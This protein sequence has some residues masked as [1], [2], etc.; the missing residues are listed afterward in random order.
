MTVAMVVVGGAIGA[1]LRYVVEVFVR[2]RHHGAFPWGTFVVNVSGA[3]VL[4]V[5]AGVVDTVAAP[6]WLMPLVGIGLCGAFTTF[7][8]FGLETVRLLEQGAWRTAMAYS[9]GSLV[10][11]LGAVAAGLAGTA[12]LLDAARVPLG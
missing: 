3:L 12:A 6:G 11:G 10:V 5:V 2:S 7:S 1:P 9:L 8:A 4:G